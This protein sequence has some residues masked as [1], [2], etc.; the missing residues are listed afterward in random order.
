MRNPHT[1]ATIAIFAV[2]SLAAAET[3]TTAEAILEQ[4][5]TATGGRAAYEKVQSEVSLGSF[6][7]PGK[8]IRGA[9]AS[10]KSAP[11]KS[12]LTMDIPGV[13]K[14]EDGSNGE[15]A[16]SRSALQGPRIKEG[17]ERAAT[18]REATFNSPLLWRKLYKSVE[19][20][21][22]ENVG[23]QVCHKLILTPNEGKPETHYY[24][25]KSHFLIKVTMTVSTPMGETP[26][27]SR[28]GDY[29]NDG[30]IVTPHRQELSALG[31][32]FIITIDSV[33]WNTDIPKDRFAVPADVQA[34]L[35]KPA[36]A[37]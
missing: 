6:E 12:Y 7:F 22:T 27:E 10:Y 21:G 28:L 33:K 24:D 18:L 30:G 37:K 19:S 17:D 25:S 3:P 15:I 14:I 2:C 1:A 23:G 9:V 13:G 4:F 35:A 34:L 26:M 5:V 20:A 36:A 31:Q 29:R 32:E 16:W 8:G 11:N